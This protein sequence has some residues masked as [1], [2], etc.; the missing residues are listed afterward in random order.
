ML[1]L[2]PATFVPR[3]A[4]ELNAR[5]PNRSERFDMFNDFAKSFRQADPFGPVGEPL[6]PSASLRGVESSSAGLAARPDEYR[7]SSAAAYLSGPDSSHVLDLDY[8]EEEVARTAGKF[9]RRS[10]MT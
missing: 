1:C 6:G 9:S 8:W 2:V 10:R 3:A 7:W 4:S 5:L